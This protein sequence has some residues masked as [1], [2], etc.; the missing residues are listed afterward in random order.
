MINYNVDPYYDDFSPD[1]N[2]HRILFRPGRAVQARELTQ[3]Q[4]ILQNQISDFAS[5]IYSQN[6][7][8]SGGQVTTNLKCN[9]LKLNTIY[10]G[11]SV[12]AANFLN[13][14]I[15]D[16]TGTMVPSQRVVNLVPGLALNQSGS[17]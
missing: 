4:T 13:Q 8:V 10:G 9:Y 5:A 2:Y 16:S 11:S 1:K 3:S 6:T 17:I 15:T 12:V 7:P 14:T